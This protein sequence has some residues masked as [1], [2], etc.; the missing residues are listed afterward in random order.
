MA[1]SFKNRFFSFAGQ[2][3]RFRN[4]GATLKSAVLGGGVKSNTGIKTLDTVLSA[5][6]SHPFITA[7]GVAGVANPAALTGTLRATGT[8]LAREFSKLSLGGKALTI[9][10]TPVAV[11]ALKSSPSARKAVIGAP[12]SLSNVGKNVGKLIESPSLQTL[13]SLIKENPLIA[14]AA[15]AIG[16]GGLGLATLPAIAAG[17]GVISRGKQ[18][19]AIEAA[20]AGLGSKLTSNEKI[21]TPA[22]VNQP[23]IAA[24]TTPPTLTQ[25]K[26]SSPSVKKKRSSTRR[27]ASANRST[28]SNRINIYNDTAPNK[29]ILIQAR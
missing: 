14:G 17:A 20:A 24:N 29:N 4:V 18:T 21:L 26:K 27:R 10:A 12:S 15:A 28:V 1:I 22:S 6:A 19:A 2:A 16:I 23:A 11:S 3:E 5:A 9:L 25:T 13:T 7:G 8:A